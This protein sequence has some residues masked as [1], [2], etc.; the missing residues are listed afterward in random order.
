MAQSTEVHTGVEVEN[1]TDDDIA[2]ELTTQFTAEELR[3]L[4]AH[5]PAVARPRGATK[6]ETAEVIVDEAREAAETVVAGGNFHVECTCGLSFRVAH[7]QTAR[8][9]AKQH[10]SDN[11]THFPRAIDGVDGSGIYGC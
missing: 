3:R 11:I 8:R 4:A 1:M 10:K 9:A 6:S 2:T 5:I 7:P